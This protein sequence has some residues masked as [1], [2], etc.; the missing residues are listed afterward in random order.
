MRQPPN[1]ELKSQVVTKELRMRRIILLG[2]LFA[3]TITV[4][5]LSLWPDKIQKQY[6]HASELL[7]TGKLKEA[8]S[9]Y[10]TILLKK[11]N[12][13]SAK[14]MLGLTLVKLSQ[15]SQDLGEATLAVAQLRDALSLDPDEPYWH[16][17]LAQLLHAQGN[18]GEAA[19]E[20][21][22][23]AKL[24]PD[25]SDLAYEAGLGTSPEIAKD[26]KIASG[27]DLTAIPGS[28]EPIPT[29][30]PTPPYSEKARAAHYQA[31]SVLWAVV[32]ID[33]SVEQVAVEKP[34]ALGLDESALRTV[35]SWS[36]HPATR[37]G[38]PIRTRIMVE[39]S[40]R[41]F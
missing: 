1:Y 6:E 22:Q 21:A 39:V 40:F 5:L 11:P 37:S 41:M 20:F 19:K 15:Q 14:I 16:K 38:T 8:Q 12:H 24:S 27:K 36:F 17:A 28:T 23:A 32:G 9:E 33:G 13:A 29:H 3:A 30:R 10:Q 7:K 25:D 18:A 26:D 35:H 31:T 2:L 34:A 4:A